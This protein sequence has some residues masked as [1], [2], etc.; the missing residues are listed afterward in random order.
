MSSIISKILDVA[1]TNNCF[2]ENLCHLEGKR[3]SVGQ[4]VHSDAS[5]ASASFWQLHFFSVKREG[6]SV[7]T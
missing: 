5:R 2:A 7:L 3:K 1:I 4:I 6:R